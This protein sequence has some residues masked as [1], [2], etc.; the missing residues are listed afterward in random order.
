MN[1]YQLAVTV[2]LLPLSSL[3]DIYGY[4]RVYLFGLVVFCF[5]SLACGLAGTLPLL[6]AGRVL[7][8]LGAAVQGPAAHAVAA[9][10]QLIGQVLACLDVAHLPD[11]QV[12]A[13]L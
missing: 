9:Q 7:Q 13:A 3:G 8:G 5:G 4:R 6:V 11:V 1:A 2:S 10:G 12:G